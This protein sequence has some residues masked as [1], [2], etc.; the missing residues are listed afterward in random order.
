MALEWFS[1]SPTCTCRRH[2]IDAQLYVTPLLVNFP[3]RPAR[4]HDAW[5]PD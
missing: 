3:S 1:V 2:E 5:L 4:D